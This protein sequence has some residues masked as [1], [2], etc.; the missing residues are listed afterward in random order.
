MISGNF[1]TAFASDLIKYLE[2]LK[3]F[4]NINPNEIEKYP[5]AF[6]IL[7]NWCL[8]L[9]NLNTD[10]IKYTMDDVD[11]GFNDYFILCGLMNYISDYIQLKPQDIKIEMK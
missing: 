6:E 2:E 11:A 3:Q 8:E 4:D 1:S 5:A 9:I 7:K 10:G